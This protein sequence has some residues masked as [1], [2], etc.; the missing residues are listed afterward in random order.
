MASAALGQPYLR[1]ARATTARQ[2]GSAPFLPR[3]EAR[4]PVQPGVGRYNRAFFTSLML[5]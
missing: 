5:F 1:A 2:N 4:T 3:G